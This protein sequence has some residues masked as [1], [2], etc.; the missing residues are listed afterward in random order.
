MAYFFLRSGGLTSVLLAA[1][2]SMGAC[3]FVASLEYSDIKVLC[4]SNRTC[5]VGLLLSIVIL[6]GSLGSLLLTKLFPGK[7]F[8]KKTVTEL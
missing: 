6:G 3:V 7:F 2:L 1:I 5:S 4:N 8:E